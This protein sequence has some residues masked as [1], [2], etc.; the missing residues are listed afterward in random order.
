MGIRGIVVTCVAL[1][2]SFVGVCEGAAQD[3]LEQS[4]SAAAPTLAPA[5]GVLLESVQAAAE[6]RETDGGGLVARETDGGSLQ[7]ASRP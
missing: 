6:G 7:P 1:V 4:E 5:P 2:G 3:P